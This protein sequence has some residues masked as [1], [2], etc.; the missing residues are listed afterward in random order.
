MA[1]GHMRSE[2]SLR[3]PDFTGR[4]GDGEIRE[5]ENLGG[6]LPPAALRGRRVRSQR[7]AE[8]ANN[9]K[10]A[11]LP[12]SPPPSED[13]PRCSKQPEKAL[14]RGGERTARARSPRA[15]HRA[16]GPAAR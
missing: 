16:R 5:G 12:V 2:P 14:I 9:K 6:A 15:T 3:V 4:R 10:L 7:A 11:N 13:W 8:A 1:S